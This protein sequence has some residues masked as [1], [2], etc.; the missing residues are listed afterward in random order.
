MGLTLYE[1]IW[2][3]HAIAHGAGGRTL[4]YI[5]RQLVHDGSFH[6]FLA[7]K[8]AGRA[9]RRPEAS[10]A[11]PD[12]YVPTHNR[13][14]ITHPELRDKVETLAAN[15]AANGITIYPV[16]DD[17]QGIVHVVGPE[18]GITQPGITLVCGDSHTSTHGAFGALAFGIG[19][20]E[21]AHVLATQALWQAPS[22]TFRVTVEGALSPGVHAKDIILA[23]IA[24]IG[25]FGGTGYTFEY[26]GPGIRALSMEARMTIC[27][28][29]IEAGAKAGLVAPDET[30]FAYLHGRPQAPK[31]EYW[32][33]AVALWRALP[34]DPDSRFDREVT[35]DASALEPMA[36]W[37]TSPEHGVGISGVVPDPSREADAARRGSM[38][39]A[40]GYMDLRPGARIDGLPIER[41]FIGSCT[42]SRLE[43][44][45]AAAEVVRGRK[46]KVPAL[47]VPGSGLVKRDA[48]AEGLD[49]VFLD[50][51]FEWRD[52]G[53]SMCV[54][55]NGD[56][57]GSGERVASTSNRNFEGRQGKGARTHLMS[58]AMAAAAAVT[59][60]ITDVRKLLR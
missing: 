50:A 3:D 31:G 58:P 43:D 11:T 8:Q 45:R 55:M 24:R 37:G 57:A 23:L 21:V 20:S 25:A 59:G 19:A 14:P 52:A 27:N 44:L 38:E 17:R 29:S 28:M 49:R 9:V 53:C 6:A 15:A 47:V 26:A 7:L 35:L 18:Q 39:K 36:T 22:K 16:G 32:E 51:G 1:K 42:N 60:C 12:H 54:G 5:D 10:F 40:L 4:L 41:V 46:A 56:L 48:E 33:R 34:S 30:T 2:N 13:H